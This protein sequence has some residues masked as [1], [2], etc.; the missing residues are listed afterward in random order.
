M[1]TSRDSRE[2]MISWRRT[3]LALMGV[4]F[5]VVLQQQLALLRN[6]VTEEHKWMERTL[7]DSTKLEFNNTDDTSHDDNDNDDDDTVDVN[8]DNAEVFRNT[9][10]IYGIIFVVVIL[11]FSVVRQKFSAYNTRSWVDGIQTHLAENKHGFMSWAWKVFDVSEESFLNECGMDALCFLRIIR[12]GYK[13]SVVAIFNS[14]FLTP[15]YY[16]APASSDTST[17]TDWL[18][19]ISIANVPAQSSFLIATVVACYIFFLYTIYLILEGM[20]F[21]LQL[22]KLFCCL[23]KRPS[24]HCSCLLGSRI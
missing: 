21:A 20:P 22:R 3:R 17:V 2:K 7:A 14:L 16:M 19:K 24:S 8:Y 4:T 5:A 10:I 18:A 15:T 12:M 23:G 13:L 6:V 11:V 9:L 1:R